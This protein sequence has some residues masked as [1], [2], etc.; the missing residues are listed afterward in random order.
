MR[1]LGSSRALAILGII[2][3]A[4]GLHLWAATQLPVDFD[5]PDYVQAGYGYAE[6][7]ARG[8]LDAV[9][10]YPFNLEHPPLVKLIYG[11][12]VLA[13]GDRATWIGALYAARLISAA[14]GVLAVLLL[15]LVDPLAGALLVTHTLAMKYTSQ[16]YLEALPFCASLAAALAL[17]RSRA[18]RDRWF[19]LSAVALGATAAGKFSYFPIVFPIVFLL[20]QQ[21]RRW[22]DLLL[23]VSVV[24]AVFWVLNP[25]LWHE[26]VARLVDMLLFH[27]RYSQSANVQ[28]SGYP[29]YQPV[30]WLSRPVPWHRQVFFYIGLDGL[31]FWL[32]I[33]G[34][35]LERRTRPWLVAWLVGGLVA[36]LLWRTKW[37][38]YALVLVPPLCMAAA[39]A[40]R[41]LV[42]KVRDW[43]DRWQVVR[44]IFPAP[45]LSFWVSILLL[46]VAVIVGMTLN[47]IRTM[48]AR[49]SW[50]HL[51]AESAPLPSNT[52]HAIL[53]IHDD[54]AADDPL[55]GGSMVM[56][57]E[58]GLAVW[59][60]AAEGGLTDRWLVFTAKD[61][62]LPHDRVLALAKD[63]DGNLWAGTGSGVGRY[64]GAVWRAYRAPDLGLDGE[65]VN[66]LGVDGAGRVWA[67]TDAGAA[68]FDRESWQ[69]YTAATS[70]LKSDYVLALAV[71]HRA[72]GAGVI[73]FGLMDGIS[74][75]DT[76]TGQWTSFTQAEAGLG[77]GGIG[78]L[79]VDSAG[80]VWVGSLGGGLSCWDGAG[81][82]GARMGGWDIPNETVQTIFES[83]PGRLW[84]GTALPLNV[85]GTLSS[86]D[87]SSWRHYT[88][89]NSGFSGA[90]PLALALGAQGQLWAGTQSAGVDIFRMEH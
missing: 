89:S 53:A 57:T 6:A 36:L 51:T 4:A 13:L 47:S 62:G 85:G 21:K 74:R 11:V 30:L 39:S 31:I 12:G 41:W 10:D 45:T 3:L 82:R 26:P 17:V 66:A 65:Q 75:L 55:P 46:A 67:G 83:E 48:T 64:D 2:L 29:W 23:Y 20:V 25:T 80:R 50:S 24:A 86:Y 27:V 76:A 16:A 33:W 70:G 72:P 71:E 90:E 7:I 43:E 8:D 68:V 61:G 60:P 28:A 35:Y 69:P 63:T 22:T 40:L 81:W 78:S 1:S 84:V 73:W 54:G 79:Y 18:P 42:Q 5:E 88:E 52:V 77:S 37:P 59:I 32:A 34:A 56:G 19:W 38:Q 58:R 49:V 15:A 87:G 9:I 44:N 14:F